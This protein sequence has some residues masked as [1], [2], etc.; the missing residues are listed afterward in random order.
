MTSGPASATPVR[1]VPEIRGCAEFFGGQTSSGPYALMWQWSGGGG[2]RNG[3]GDFD[4][5]AAVRQG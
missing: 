5:I 4:Q 2:I 3:V 1:M